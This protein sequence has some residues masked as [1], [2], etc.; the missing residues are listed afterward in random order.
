[1]GQQIGWNW[2]YHSSF[3]ENNTQLG[4]VSKLN[5]EFTPKIYQ[6]DAQLE[7]FGLF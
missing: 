7:S 4:N 2:I 5:S 3:Y 6:A 1:M